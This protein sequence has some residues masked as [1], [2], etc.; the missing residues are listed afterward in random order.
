MTIIVEKKSRTYSPPRSVSYN[1][2][3]SFSAIIL[4]S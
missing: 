4:R 1:G 3:D 2:R